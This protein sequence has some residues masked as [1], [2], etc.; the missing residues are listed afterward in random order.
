MTEHFPDDY[1]HINRTLKRKKEVGRPECDITPEQAYMSISTF[2]GTIW[3]HPLVTPA[4]ETFRRTNKPSADRIMKCFAD[5]HPDVYAAAI[6]VGSTRWAVE[7]ESDADYLVIAFGKTDLRALRA[8]FDKQHIVGSPYRSAHF[9]INLNPYFLEERLPYGNI[10]FTRPT[11]VFEILIAPDEI[12]SGNV[13]LIQYLRRA[14]TQGDFFEPYDA[15]SWERMLIDRVHEHTF[16]WPVNKGMFGEQKRNRRANEVLEKRSQLSK[17]PK[18]YKE[19]FIR[20]YTKLAVPTWQEYQLA[21]QY[22]K[23][24]LNFPTN[25]TYTTLNLANYAEAAS[26]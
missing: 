11:D 15:I 20:A 19:A 25:T 22:S 18:R 3:N 4:L 16:G 14:L 23:G 9:L 5:E 12:V 2:A 24:V 8:W 17:T 13:E 21:M 6:P 10:S 1:E 26:S 7:P